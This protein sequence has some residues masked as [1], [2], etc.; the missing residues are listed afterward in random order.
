M[1]RFFTQK[2]VPTPTEFA[3][4]MDELYG[5]L[6]NA[7]WPDGRWVGFSLGDAL[8]AAKLLLDA[9][10]SEAAESGLTDGEGDKPSADGRRS[11]RRCE[12]GDRGGWQGPAM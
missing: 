6:D 1:L 10:V 8:M 4:T 5:V 2:T 9:A 11:R 12:R 7:G 3:D